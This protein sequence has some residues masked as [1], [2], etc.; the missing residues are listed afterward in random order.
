[1][2]GFLISSTDTCVSERP[3]TSPCAESTQRVYARAEHGISRANISENALKVL[4]RLKDAGFRACLVGGGVRDLLLGREPKDFDVA[5]D[6]HPED[7]RR[8]FRNCRLIG[9]RFRLAHVYFGREIIEVAT[10]RAPHDEGDGE[11]QAE[12]GRIIRDNVYGNIEQDAWRRDFSINALYYDIRDFSVV[13]YTGGMEDL[14]QGVLRLIGDPEVRYREDPVRMLRAVRFAAK[15]GFRVDPAAEEGMVRLGGLLEDV[16]PARLFDEVIKLFHGG[17][18]L[19]TFEMLRHYDLFRRLFP[20]TE[21]ALEREEQGY[22]ITFV[23]NALRNTDDRIQSGKGVHPAF[24]YAVLLWEPVRHEAERLMAEGEGQ[25]PALQQAGA[26]ILAEQAQSILIPKRFALPVREIWE[27]QPRFEQRQGARALRL[28][29]H[30]RFRAAYDFYCLR[31]RSGEALDDG[32]QWWT[33][34][35]EVDEAEQR[36]MVEATGR[37]GRKRRRRRRKPAQ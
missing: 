21:R 2:G 5:T 30:P 12:D 34:L 3:L 29:G 13:D 19:Q 17:A 16:S 18:A 33:R 32:C 28:L 20:L 1:M 10:F 8:I 31:G 25:V 4:Y 22:P 23:A 27:L 36:R 9:R 11:A 35:Q 15:L 37:S 6:A 14:R 26:R 24:L 7:V